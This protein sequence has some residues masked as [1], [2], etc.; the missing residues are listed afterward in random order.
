MG[1]MVALAAADATGH[2]FEFMDACDKPGA[3]A[4]STHATPPPQLDFQRPPPLPTTTARFPS[5]YIS[6]RLLAVSQ[7]KALF[8]VSRLE[9][10][11]G[12]F[13]PGDKDRPHP[14]APGGNPPCFSGQTFNKFFL[15]MGQWTDD[16]SMGLAM[17]RMK[18]IICCTCWHLNWSVLMQADSLILKRGA[19]SVEES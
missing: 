6:L 10:I 19:I 18:F 4:V 15:Q 14:N 8:E 5:R 7:T 3:S 1:S 11:P 16:C 12:Q 17:V 9:F 2:W 13:V